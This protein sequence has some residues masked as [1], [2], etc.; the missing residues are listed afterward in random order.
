M[1][2]DYRCTVLFYQLIILQNC[3]ALNLFVCLFFFFFSRML[4][5]SSSLSAVVNMML[6]QVKSPFCLTDNG[7]NITK[8]E[9]VKSKKEKKQQIRL[10]D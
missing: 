3:I 6:Y 10:K 8:P 7:N 2:P 1:G 4:Q 9:T 5:G